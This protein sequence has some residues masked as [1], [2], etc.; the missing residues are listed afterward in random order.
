MRITA[1]K[2]GEAAVVLGDD[3]QG[4]YIA[5]SPRPRATVETQWQRGL[6]RARKTPKPRYNEQL[7][8]SWTVDREHADAN[9]AAKFA[10]R[11]KDDVP[12]GLVTLTIRYDDGFTVYCIN[13]VI[14]VKE[15]TSAIGQSTTYYYHFVAEQTSVTAPTS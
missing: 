14:D 3:A 8:G 4:D 12:T 7:E 6:R 11:H 13:A 10:M 9:A 15:C 1:K 2:T 5:D